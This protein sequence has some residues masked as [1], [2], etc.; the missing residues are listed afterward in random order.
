MKIYG[1][2]IA[3]TVSLLGGLVGLGGAEF[4][5]PFLIK[6]FGFAPLEA[7]IINKATSLIVVS[8]SILSRTAVIPLDEVVK[9][10]FI[11]FNL[12]VGS[13]IGAYLTADWA[14]KIRSHLLQKI[15]ATLL[16]FIAIVLVFERGFSHFKLHLHHTLLYPLGVIA[17]IFIGAVSA[18]L[19]VA[20]GEFLI[21]TI[22]LLYHTDI[23]MAGS[24]SLLV[25]LPT[26]FFAFVR[27]SKDRSFIVLKE[28]KNF[29]V[30]MTL[31][32]ILGSFVG[33]NLLLGFISQ[34]GILSLLIIIL[35]VSSLKL[36]RH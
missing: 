36:L 9:N 17:G 2:I 32:S 29:M 35:I 18:L 30:V 3:F 16:L 34:E 5:L 15:I 4:R 10:L 8:S 23:K 27:Y 7:V 25:S 31:G 12:L 33:G 19:G 21:P 22:T 24:L 14:T 28:N 1:F 13:L 26:M 11:V 6:L 20:G